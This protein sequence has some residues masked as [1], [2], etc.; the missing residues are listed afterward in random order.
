[1]KVS[2]S[3]EFQQAFLTSS[4]VNAMKNYKN[5]DFDIHSFMSSD[6][7]LLCNHSLYFARY[8]NLCC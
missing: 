6:L 8:Y 1:M 4:V 7:G 5:L 2:F 3:F